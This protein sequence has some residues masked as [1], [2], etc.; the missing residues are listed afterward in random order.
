MPFLF[1]KRRSRK[2]ENKE[3]RTGQEPG[4]D[5]T[6]RHV[7]FVFLLITIAKTRA[8]YLFG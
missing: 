3:V 8:L 1:I 6:G 2:K 4:S 7:I 5:I